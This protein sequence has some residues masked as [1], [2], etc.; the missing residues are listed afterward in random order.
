MPTTLPHDAAAHEAAVHSR[1]VAADQLREIAKPGIRPVTIGV[2]VLVVA[3]IV[4]SAVLFARGS[5]EAALARGLISAGV[6]TTSTNAGQISTVPLSDGSIAKLGPESRMRVPADFGSS[7]R[8]VEL[9]GTASFTVAADKK[10]PFLVRA[11]PALITA[12]GT[13]FA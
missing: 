6:Q 11:G 10:P 3:A 5:D 2:G 7:T 12:T 1:H 9:T 8:G 4:A 13:E